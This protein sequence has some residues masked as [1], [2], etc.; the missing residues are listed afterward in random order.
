MT[1]QPSVAEQSLVGSVLLG[2]YRV[3]RE[4]AR[5]GMGV[6][7]LA[8]AEGAVGFVKP[9]VI[10]VLLPEHTDD[11]HMV[12]MFAREARILSQLRHPSLVDVI[13]FGEHDGGYALVLEYVRGYHLGLWLRYLSAKKRSVPTPI[14][15]QICIDVLEALHH[16]HTQVHPDGSS[17]QIVHRDVS[18]SNILLDESGRARLLDF[19]VARMR[20]GSHDFRTQVHGFMGKL[21]YTA[22]EVFSGSEASP[23]SDLYACAVVLHEVLTGQNAFRAETQAATLQRVLHHV[24]DV[25]E[26]QVPD[27]PVGLDAVL[28]RAL[29]KAP[30]ARHADARELA[31]ELRRL[32]GENESDIRARLAELLQNDFG[33]EMAQLLK[34]ESLAERDAAWRDAQATRESMQRSTHGDTA[35]GGRK[36]NHLALARTAEPVSAH[37]LAGAPDTP[38]PIGHTVA[39]S[40]NARTQHTR[41]ALRRITGENPAVETEPSTLPP[42]AADERPT[43]PVAP[44]TQLAEPAALDPM[45][46]TA[47]RVALTQSDAPTKPQT[48]ADTEQPES[49]SSPE[50]PRSRAALWPLGT[51]LAVTTLAALWLWRPQPRHEPDQHTG[52]VTAGA[53]TVTPALGA[54]K[55]ATPNP[56]TAVAPVP[57]ITAT[58]RPDTTAASPLI[59]PEPALIA[60]SAAPQPTA[61]AAHT[62]PRS[63]R[64]PDASALTQ[65][66]RKR[67]SKLE[68]CFKQHSLAL[69]GQ[70][71]TQLEFELAI[72]G[73]PTRVE[74]SPR[75]LTETALGQCLL[76]VARHTPFP[77]QPRAVSFIIPLTASASRGD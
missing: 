64:T 52:S 24:T 19:G 33:A 14:V 60:A 39:A 20:G 45:R 17:M 56:P 61:A 9:V 58:P 27:A 51:L 40:P 32:R 1:Q 67:Q 3:V 22:P 53:K 18:P 29:S 2:R 65:A 66:L 26:A 21:P 75:R 70:P 13:E 77:P 6:V 11:E 74:L 28:S 15:L 72:D 54:L 71:T 5:G 47:R 50:R 49:R 10:K 48:A 31:A 23:Q 30:D 55:S 42:S 62:K 43:L 46:D 38:A 12:R 73:T 57:A 16:A 35:P 8:R 41:S 59:A 7:Y 76:R 37:A 25:I 63:K 36:H 69:E 4:L 34:L 44:H 68:A